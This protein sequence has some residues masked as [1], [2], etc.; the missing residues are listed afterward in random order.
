MT[1]C[2]IETP[3][4]ERW[5]DSCIMH[6]LKGSQMACCNAF[7][8][9]SQVRQRRPTSFSFLFKK[10]V[11]HVKIHVQRVCPRKMHLTT[12]K[13]GEWSCGSHVYNEVSAGWKLNSLQNT[14]LAHHHNHHHEHHYNH[15]PPLS[16]I[17][18][19]RWPPAEPSIS[20]A[21]KIGSTWCSHEALPSQDRCNGIGP[22]WCFH[23]RRERRPSE[24]KYNGGG[25]GC[26][27]GAN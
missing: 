10:F 22:T 17:M 9:A 24:D 16:T 12:S 15:H 4:L 1:S 7:C 18:N 13:S 21:T 11:F 2:L 25:Q 14:W 6:L 27:S 19:Y 3:E 5:L 8:G 20:T 23:E 26:R